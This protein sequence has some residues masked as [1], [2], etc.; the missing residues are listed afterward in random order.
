MA[1][2]F[3]RYFTNT[4]EVEITDRLVK[5]VLVH[6]GRAMAELFPVLQTVDAPP[7]RDLAAVFVVPCDAAERN[8]PSYLR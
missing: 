8:K 1:H 5:P 3:E 4:T 2:V 7:H 6:S